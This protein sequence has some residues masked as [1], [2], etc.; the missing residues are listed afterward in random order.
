[1]N[2]EFR[3]ASANEWDEP[4]AYDFVYSRVMLQ[5]LPRRV[6]VLR[7]MW[8]AV[9]PG[10]V[11]AAEDADSGGLFCYPANDG[12]AFY[13]PMMPLVIASNGGDA[14]FGLRLH[15]RFL[16][17]GIREPQL[18]LAQNVDADGG[19]KT[20][21]LLTLQSVSAAIVAAGLAT[22]AEVT[23]AI[24]DLAAFTAAPG[25]IIGGP[26]IL[27]AWARKELDERQDIS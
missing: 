26:R 24:D 22:E 21:S 11:L 8:N 12:F 7:R 2:L 10:G 16:G 6:E 27:Q 15:E 18:S 14:L 25:T 4:G 19:S 3:A 20:M 17:L 23:A 5:H 13:K 9:R 1:M